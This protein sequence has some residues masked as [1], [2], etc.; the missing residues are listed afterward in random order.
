MLPLEISIQTYLLLSVLILLTVN[1]QVTN[2]LL[3][4]KRKRIL[5]VSIHKSQLHTS[6]QGL[7]KLENSQ[8]HLI[9]PELPTA[10]TKPCHF[11][12]SNQPHIE[13]SVNVNNSHY[14]PHRCMMDLVATF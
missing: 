10:N 6:S 8:G 11:L 4:L 14:N 7:V 9:H 5:T 3:I 1:F 13:Q 2:A 12:P